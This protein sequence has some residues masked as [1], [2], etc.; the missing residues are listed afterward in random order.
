MN[1]LKRLCASENYDEF[2]NYQHLAEVLH[3]IIASENCDNKSLYLSIYLL[4]NLD[5]PYA[6]SKIFKQSKSYR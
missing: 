6:V 4:L 5:N 1:G 2:M 3:Q